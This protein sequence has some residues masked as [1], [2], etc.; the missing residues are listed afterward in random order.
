MRKK[1]LNIFITLLY[2]QN[3]TYKFI[4][5]KKTYCFLLK[6][7]EKNKNYQLELLTEKNSFS[8]DYNLTKK[9]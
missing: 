7:Y 4:K 6:E 2:D 3:E 1:K 9:F 5:L 8:N